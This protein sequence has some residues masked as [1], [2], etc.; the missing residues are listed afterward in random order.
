MLFG[1]K[2]L[3]V[4]IFCHLFP[5]RP[6]HHPWGCLGA[7]VRPLTPPDGLA[8]QDPIA[9]TPCACAAARGNA[10][11]GRG[12]RLQHRCGLLTLTD[13]PLQPGSEPAPGGG[14]ICDEG[15][16][17]L[18]ASPAFPTTPCPPEPSRVY[19]TSWIFHQSSPSMQFHPVNDKL[20]A[21]AT[22]S[23]HSLL[24]LVTESIAED[25][26]QMDSRWVWLG[27]PHGPPPSSPSL[28]LHPPPAPEAH[29]DNPNTSSVPGGKKPSTEPYQAS[30]SS[31][32]LP[33]SPQPPGPRVPAPAPGAA[34]SSLGRSCALPF[35][36]ASTQFI[37]PPPCVFASSTFKIT[38][39]PSARAGSLLSVE[40]PKAC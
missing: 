8:A 4:A 15:S 10:C 38:F 1:D 37:S 9:P 19:K 18:W 28:Q 26:R 2:H 25:R 39:L 7:L 34:G 12:L 21:E 27:S 32:V 24:L 17:P 30:T 13:I 3:S 11:R 20:V 35:P 33:R 14:P 6:Q 5:S 22:L 40:K 23:A 31:P 36:T 29:R 16:K